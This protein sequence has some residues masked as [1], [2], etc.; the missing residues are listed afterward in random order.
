MPCSLVDI[1]WTTQCYTPEENT[2]HIH[3]CENLRAHGIKMDR[4][5]E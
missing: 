2:I 1:Y 5:I 3:C 4:E